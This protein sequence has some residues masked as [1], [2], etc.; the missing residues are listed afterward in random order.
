MPDS[1]MGVAVYGLIRSGTTLVSDLLTVRGQSLVISEPDLFVPWDARAVTRIYNTAKAFGLPVADSVPRQEQYGSFARYF[2]QGLIPHLQ[3]LDLWGIKQVQFILWRE[4]F[5]VLPPKHLIL[6]LRDLREVSLSAFDLIGRMGLIFGATQVLRDEAWVMTRLCHDVYELTAMTSL[7]HLQLRY[8]D[9]VTDKTLRD[10]LAQ[11]VSLK[12]LGTERLNLEGEP[13][14]RSA[15]EQSKHQ[16]T[17]SSSSLDRFVDEPP[18]PA[19]SIAKRI[20]S[21]LPRY[22]E[23][24]GYEAPGTGA[25]ITGHSLAT[26]PRSGPNPVSQSLIGW[27]S[28]KPKEFE[29]AFSRRHAR[30]AA[31]RMIQEKTV[32]LDLGC[33]VPALKLML[34]PGCNYIGSDVA[35]RF[36]GC[37]VADYNAGEMPPHSRATLVTVLGLLEHIEDVA[38]FMKRIRAYSV[39]VLLSYHAVE[40][41]PGIDRHAFGWKNSFTRQE[42]VTIVTAAGFDYSAHWTF[43]GCQSLLELNPVTP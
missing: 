10:K 31:A 15:W 34:P 14:S 21:I 35:K 16:N 28:E 11:Y 26:D 41:S 9:L 38:G 19:K 20:W 29:P 24:F 12:A 22:S 5:K 42:L 8:E 4:L 23:Q 40:D 25:R 18:G 36:D 30:V 7:P 3:N 37:L 33:V 27:S 6:C 32:V 13:D 17:I 39:R 1:Q 2:E 43:D